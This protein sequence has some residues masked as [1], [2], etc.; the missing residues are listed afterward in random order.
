METLRLRSLQQPAQ[1][2]RLLEAFVSRG[3]CLPKEAYQ[4]RNARALPKP[5]RR[6]I[7][8]A[9]SEG[10]VWTC[11]EHGVHLSLFTCE[12]ALARSRERG[13][14]VLEVTRHDESGDLVDAGNWAADREGRWV[15]CAE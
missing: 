14:P 4:I 15:R 1:L 10:R 9:A 12:L 8:M 2:G 5:L 13:A 6:L 11:W 3:E 7:T